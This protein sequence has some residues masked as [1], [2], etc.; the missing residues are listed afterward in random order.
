MTTMTET[1]VPDHENERPA[2]PAQ[3]LTIDPA[4]Y[5]RARPDYPRDAVVWM[6]GVDRM[7]VLE[8]GA[9]TGKLTTTL[10]D[11]GHDVMATDPDERLLN[12][13]R[14]RHPEARTAVTKAESI[15]FASRSADVV[16]V[17][18]SFHR[19]DHSRAL[20]EVY[21]LLRP[22][23]TLSLVW[24]CADV[25]VPWVKKLGRIVGGATFT[26]D[27]RDPTETLTASGLFDEVERATFRH[28]VMVDKQR[29]RELVSS[30]A[31][32]AARDE[33]ERASVLAAVDALY[34]DYQRGSAGMQLPY[35]S[36]C[37]RSVA[38]EAV[39]HK[40]DEQTM[41]MDVANG[42]DTTSLFTFN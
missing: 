23:G 13:L 6:T 26:G 19:F 28:W 4:G 38:L 36:H 33:R 20:S 11:L 25:R 12:V 18:Q 34:D 42:E 30:H 22:Q 17:A 29:L 10:L 35:I 31:A 1:D 7:R 37:Y 24:N 16:A 39:P 27:D 41:A 9:G 2:A 14:A 21:R 3:G 8:L 40:V 32:V 15:P 5:D